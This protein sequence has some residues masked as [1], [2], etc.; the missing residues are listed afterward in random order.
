MVHYSISPI[1]HSSTFPSVP[2]VVALCRRSSLGSSTHS[3]RLLASSDLQPDPVI[4]PDKIPAGG[5]RDF[6]PS[7]VEPDGEGVAAG[8]GNLNSD[9]FGA[10]DIEEI[11]LREGRGGCQEGGA[12]GEDGLGDHLVFGNGLTVDCLVRSD[13]RGLTYLAGEDEAVAVCLI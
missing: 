6:I 11:G 1:S 10:R 5:M 13:V 4:P 12:D 7:H 8:V 3:T 2:A 9:P